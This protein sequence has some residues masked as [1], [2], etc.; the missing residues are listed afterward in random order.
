MIELKDG[1][2]IDADTYCYSLQRTREYVDKSG[3][4][5]KLAVEPSYHKTVKEALN[6]YLQKLQRKAIS[7]AETGISMSEA[8]KLLNSIQEEVQ[9]MIREEIEHK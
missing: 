8:V 6:A 2:I 9:T 7:E 3:R 1:W 5:V 4:K